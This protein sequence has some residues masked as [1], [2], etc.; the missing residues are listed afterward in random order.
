M[1]NTSSGQSGT[2]RKNGFTLLEVLAVAVLIALLFSVG[3]ASYG[4]TFNRWAVEQNARQLYMAAK[5]ARL[6]AVEYQQDCTL[7]LDRENGQFFLMTNG[8]NDD[9]ADEE[10]MLVSNPWSRKV[11]L[12][13]HVSFEA[14]KIAGRDEDIEGGVVFRPD[15][16][17]DNAAIQL[18]DGKVHYTVM[19]NGGTSRAH[20]LEG[21]AEELQTDQID[22]DMMEEV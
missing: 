1:T 21:E 16:T 17:A 15:G 11:V 18:G 13:N 20:L 8:L 22:L 6:Y 19:V 14:V 12:Q 7:V 4:R 10:I 5:S 2:A 9:A 3:I